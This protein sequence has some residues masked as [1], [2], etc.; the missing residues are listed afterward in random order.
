MKIA[1]LLG[2]LAIGGVAAM[3][4][5][6]P[7]EARRGGESVPRRDAVWCRRLGVNFAKAPLEVPP[8]MAAR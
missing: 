2:A 8:G 1:L 5:A 3:K 6:A 7:A 4:I